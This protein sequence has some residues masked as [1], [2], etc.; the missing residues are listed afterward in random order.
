MRASRRRAGRRRPPGEGERGRPAPEAAAWSWTSALLVAALAAGVYANTLDGALLYDDVNAV[1]DN[2]W[3][4]S[5]DPAGILTHP[6]WWREGHGRGW[7]PVATLSFALNH[8]LH[9]LEPRGY[10]LVNVALHAGVSVLVLAV[11]ARATGA[12]LPALVAALLFA[13]HPVHTEAVAS[14]VGRAELLAAGGFFL[15][16]LCFLRADAGGRPRLLEG[17]GVAAFV[18]GLLAKENAITLL[19]VLVL[20][21]LIRPAGGSVPAALGR[22]LPRYGALAA[23]CAVVLALRRQVIGAG[24]P[25]IDVL[26]NPLVALPA[27]ERLLTAVK[28]AGL[29]AWRLLAPLR[30]S[31]D[32]SFRQIAP[33]ESPLDPAF[34]A[35]LAVVAGVPA[36]AWAA[37]R[38]AVP[39][40]LGLGMLA[41]T[42]SLV[43][44]LAFPIG[45][46]MAERLVYLPSAGFCLAAGAGLVRLAGERPRRLAPVVGVVL[47]LYAART[48]TRN[49]V[50]R[51]PEA[52]FTA[53]V[54]DAPHSAR[55]HRELGTMLAAAG[56][57]D[58]ARPAFERSL[59]I[60]PNDAATLYN[61]GNALLQAGRVDEAIDAYGRALAAKPDFDDAMVN[62]GNA[63]SMRGDHDAALGWMRRALARAPDSATLRM[64]VAN[65]LFR[66]GRLAEARAEYEA[67]LALAPD[68]PAILTNYGAFLYAHGDLDAAVDAYRRAAPSA[69][70][71]VGLAASYRAKGMRAEAEAAQARAEALFPADPS[72]RQMAQ[73][74][75]ADAAAGG[76]AP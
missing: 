4:R 28:V 47:A 34:L 5:G 3:V 27:V 31:A 40:A 12:A 69:R 1:V 53:M 67:A 64:N 56:R 62:L 8:A 39:V 21:D 7:R 19:P 55:S 17:A 43:A 76:T 18:A 71:L 74:L 26:D 37:R 45:T 58:E 72:V 48:W 30:L 35:G 25:G 10:H 70:A 20:A 61:L 41:L 52:F 54:A 14:V 22:H 15:A 16:W 46:I 11:F 13:A 63:E 44:N 23:A 36:L 66:L 42:F 68:A 33:V 38:R 49:E 60:K 65:T 50:W 73:V 29:Y 57:L 75:R 9:G 32:Y 6:S 51:T 59:A 24:A 2:A